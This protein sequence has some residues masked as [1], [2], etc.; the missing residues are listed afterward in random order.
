MR[1]KRQLQFHVVQFDQSGNVLPS[2]RP[3]FGS[4]GQDKR[5]GKGKENT[6][7]ATLCD[8]SY[9]THLQVQSQTYRF[10]APRPAASHTSIQQCT[11]PCQHS[12]NGL[13]N[14]P[15]KLVESPKPVE[16]PVKRSCEFPTTTSNRPTVDWIERVKTFIWSKA[17]CFKVSLWKSVD[18]DYCTISKADLS[19]YD[20]RLVL[21]PG[22]AP[23]SLHVSLG[24]K[25]SFKVLFRDTTLRGTLKEEKDISSLLTVMENYEVCPGL[26]SV[27]DA[28]S[29]SK[30]TWGFPFERI[31]SNKCLLLHLPVNTKQL[32]GSVLFN[33][34]QHCKKLY[35]KL[36][37]V[38]KKRRRN[39]ANRVSKSSKCNWRFL[40]P[41]SAKKRFRNLTCDARRVSK[42]LKRLSRKV[43][44][45]LN[46]ELSGQMEQITNKIS[47]QFHEDL[48]SIFEEAEVK[49]KG[50]GKL[51][52]AMWQQDVDE[53][54]AFWKDQNRNGRHLKIYA[55]RKV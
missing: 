41:K 28:N 17:P 2:K 49:T 54:N 50:N 12:T 51:L 16:T 10:I 38:S 27:P 11:L 43:Q 30:R 14:I 45:S 32:P 34:C 22:V 7:A 26:K 48:N 36:N 31:D 42:Q 15:E 47:S 1:G 37:D 4:D 29:A 33:V 24:G 52:R 20:S 5:Y 18:G 40:S 46:S 23:V 9:A 25:Y 21:V 44:V 3:R 8:G 35:R 55:F 6:I 39:G 13:E 53:K 19:R